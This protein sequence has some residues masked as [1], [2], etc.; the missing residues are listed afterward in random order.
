[1]YPFWL[2]FALQAQSI[3]MNEKIPN[4]ELFIVSD[5]NHSVH[6]EKPELVLPKI[7]QFLHKNSVNGEAKAGET[8]L[9]NGMIPTQVPDI[10]ISIGMSII[11]TDVSTEL[12]WCVT[13]RGG[14][15][16]DVIVQIPGRE[17]AI[18]KLLSTDPQNYSDAPTEAIRRAL[19][20]AEGRTIA[21]GEKLDG[22][23]IESCRIGTTVATNALLEKKG[24][25]FALLTTKGKEDCNLFHLMND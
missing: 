15:F 6:L 7:R 3:L 14:T 9:L 24:E 12:T 1:M 22:S 20:I 18:F 13:D 23:R 5:A 4:S 11:L 2:Y 19:E 17:D 10:R 16:C 8:L 21:K 25:K